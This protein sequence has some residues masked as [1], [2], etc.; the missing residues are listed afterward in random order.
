MKHWS[1]IT[2]TQKMGLKK[3]YELE[4]NIATYLIYRMKVYAEKILGEYH[5]RSERS[6]I[7]AIHTVEQILQKHKEYDRDGYMVFIDFRSAFD[8]TKKT[9]V[10]RNKKLLKFHQ[11]LVHY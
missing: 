4:I 1:H 10:L 3:L 11:N 7:D 8:R 5:F 2:N 6:T 9:T